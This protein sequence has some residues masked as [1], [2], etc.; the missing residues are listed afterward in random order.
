MEVKVYK[1]ITEVDE[2]AWDAIVENNR[3]ICTH[4]YLE[5]IEKSEINDCRYYYPVLY[6]NGE[7]IA[8][9]CVYFISTELDTFAQG[10]PKKLINTIRQCWK[11]FFVLRSLECGTPIAAGTTISFRNGIDRTSVLGKICLEVECLAK[12]FGVKIVLF[13]D[14]YDEELD[15]YNCLT[16]LGYSRVHNL[17]STRMEIKWKSFDEYLNSMRSQYRW[18][19]VNRMKKLDRKNI[20][21]RVL[22][23][24]KE[25]PDELERLWTN[26][27][28]RA[29][30]Y[31]REKL[32]AV[33]FS[34]VDKYLGDQSCIVLIEKDGTPIGFTL[35]FFDDET[36]IPLY[37]GLDYNYNQDYGVYFNLLY[38]T[39]GIGIERGMRDID[40]GIT[41]LA[42]KTEMGATVV[43]MNMYMKHFNPLLNRLVPQAFE[44]MTPQNGTKPVRV[45]KG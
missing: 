39:I 21:V 3:L 14:F 18:K 35:L 4:K 8:H 33:F 11:S 27:Y 7:I 16:E 29:K 10:I 30:E 1:S 19:V 9:T 24:W 36:L 2:N 41:T 38:K 22:S 31:R 43:T 23:S 42:P 15:F 34:N 40:L 26:V 13:R 45:F 25:Y 37:S 28:D 12:N 17:P 6:E 20:T 32:T 44:T 5:A